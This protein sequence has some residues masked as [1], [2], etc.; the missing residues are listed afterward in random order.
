[1]K[2]LLNTK[3]TMRISDPWE[4]GEALKWEAFDAEVILASDDTLLI[5][6]LDPF[7]YHGTDCEFFVASPRHQGDHVEQLR[8]GKTL[9]CGLTRI[10]SEQAKSN[11]PFNLTKWRGGIAIIGNLDPTTG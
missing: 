9:F 10:T 4:L 1:M 3:V 8:N 2:A 5:R 6:L 7:V 11:D